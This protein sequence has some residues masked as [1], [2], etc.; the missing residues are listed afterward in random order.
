[1]E[2]TVANDML[3]VMFGDLE[4]RASSSYKC[5]RAGAWICEAAIW[6]SWWHRGRLTA[7]SGCRIM[8]L[9][10]DQFYKIM[11]RGGA[12]FLDPMSKYAQVFAKHIANEDDYNDVSFDYSRTDMFATTSFFTD[13]NGSESPNELGSAQMLGSRDSASFGASVGLGRRMLGF[14]KV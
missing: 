1:M 13:F 4:Y 9:N 3:H 6:G 10:D 2:H 14:V 7:A 8:S 5:V 12:Q 11:A